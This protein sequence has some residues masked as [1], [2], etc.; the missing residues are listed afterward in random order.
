M[1]GGGDRDAGRAVQEHVAVD[2]L[3]GSA[4]ASGD[5]QRI[6]TR[7]GRG[8]SLTVALDDGARL[9]AGQ[10]G[11]DIRNG[12]GYFRFQRVPPGLSSKRIPR[13]ASALRMPSAAPKS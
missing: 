10:L 1:P 2:N 4:G 9:R 3:D 7:V 12:R 5:D 13:S 8:D 11:P 6:V